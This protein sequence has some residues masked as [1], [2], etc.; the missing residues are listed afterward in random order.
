MWVLHGFVGTEQNDSGGLRTSAWY[1]LAEGWYQQLIFTLQL[2]AKASTSF[3]LA[4]SCQTLLADHFFARKF[5]W[6]IP[7][8]SSHVW[9][10]V[11]ILPHLPFTGEKP[12]VRSSRNLQQTETP[13]HGPWLGIPHF[14]KLPCHPWN[15]MILASS[16][17]NIG[18]FAEFE[19]ITALIK[20]VLPLTYNQWMSL[21][22]KGW[23]KL[24]QLDPCWV[25]K[26]VF[27]PGM[28]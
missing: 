20:C 17:T 16:K 9:R 27:Q 11:I 19:L 24:Y 8:C 3:S 13:V 23:Y 26:L 7:D 4:V 10:S 5:L 22:R 2:K 14:L 1:V 15:P 12:Y 25:P 28:E 6:Y 21:R 18:C